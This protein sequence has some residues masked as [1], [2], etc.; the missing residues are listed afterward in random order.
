MGLTQSQPDAAQPPATPEVAAR[1]SSSTKIKSARL[2]V[3]SM[4]KA[5]SRRSTRDASSAEPEAK[6]N[7]M[8]TP[9]TLGSG[10]F[11]LQHRVVMAPLTRHRATEP[12]LAPRQ[13]NVDYYRQRASAGGLLISEAVAISPEGYGYPHVPGIWT[14]HQVNEWKNVTAA[15]HEKDC[16]ISCQLWHVGRVAHP[17]YGNHPLLA[18]SGRPLPSVSS[19]AVPIK[20][21][22]KPYG[23]DERVPHATPRELPAEEI[24]RLLEDYKAAARNAMEA[25]FDLVEIHGAHG[26]LIDQ[27]LC[28]GVNKRT[29]KY[30]GSIENRCRL[31][32]EVVEAVVSVVGASRTALRLSPTNPAE[33]G[34][35]DDSDPDALF[36]FAI[37]GLDKYNLAYLLLTEP[38]WFGGDIDKGWAMPFFHPQKFRSLYKS[39]MIGS[40]GFT[41][42]NAH[43]ALDNSL[44]DAVA[45]GRW[46]ISNPDLPDRLRTGAPLNKYVRNTFYTY[47]EEGYTDYPTADGSEGVQGKYEQVEQDQIGTSLQQLEASS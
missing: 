16:L 9:L 33:Q 5:I 19:S 39:P 46:F 47:D 28:D 11:T 17:A 27:F 45:F 43:Q 7:T 35:G 29:D 2:S 8:F 15:V 42:T 12:E 26:Y 10:R 14:D 1:R 37:A 31:L 6:K 38:R 24:P 22:T 13:M 32:F 30:G 20:G 23:H 34:D 25:G 40:G 36:S 41:P 3:K 4:K 18:A 21:M 44:Y